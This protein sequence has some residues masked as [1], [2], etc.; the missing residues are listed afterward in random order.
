[1]VESQYDFNQRLANERKL[2]AYYT[3]HSHC[4]S[5]QTM[6]EF[7]KETVI[8]EP[9]IGDGSAVKIVTNKREEDGKYIFGVEL[10]QDT[11]LSVKEDPAFEEVLNEDFLH[12]IKST[13]GA[14]SFCFANPPYGD[15]ISNDGVT[16]GRLETVHLVRIFQLMKKDGIL[17]IVVPDYVIRTPEFAR[18]LLARFKPL[19]VYRF[20]E[21]EYRKFKQA[22]IVGRRKISIG[23][24]RNELDEFLEQVKALPV[25]PEVWTQEK[26]V[27]PE[28]NLEN[29][30]MFC[31]VTFDASNAV[32][33]I[34]K[35][36]L[37]KLE[38]ERLLQPL[39]G[40]D[41]KHPPIPLK[42]N[43]TYLASVGGIGQGKVG[44]E[45]EGT[46]HYQRGSAK[47]VETTT[48]QKNEYGKAEMIVTTSSRIVMKMV[49]ADGTITKLQ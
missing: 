13:N 29:M 49:E 42:D 31:P 4:Q 40:T 44:N 21:P 7:G 46:F 2:G 14:F 25:L 15:Y 1:M 26:V 43:L 39:F 48:I 28:S 3:D 16:K 35:S 19:H 17:C 24:Y 22:V 8:L 11:Y 30:K 36:A 41:D 5:I 32:K 37:R 18:I 23:Y 47:Q 38:K 27:V 12:G 45:D 20:R 9:D 10:N 34:G 33:K 6:F